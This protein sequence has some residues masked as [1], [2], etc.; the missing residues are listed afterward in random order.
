LEINMFKS[1]VRKLVSP[2]LNPLE[3]SPGEF[4]YS[5]SHRTI[6]RIMGVLFL[7]VAGVGGYFAWQIQQ[8][9][10]LLPVVLFGGV[11][12]MC[13]AIAYVGSDKAVAKLWRNR[14]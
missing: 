3:K 7:G 11:G 13:L 9:A 1:L 12:L 5:A 10:G 6:L 4:A 8:W 14:G 2:V